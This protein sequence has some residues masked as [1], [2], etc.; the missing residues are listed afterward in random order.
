MTRTL[1]KS[2]TQIDGKGEIYEI[3]FCITRENSGRFRSE[4]AVM[5]KDNGNPKIEHLDSESERMQKVAEALFKSNG[6]HGFVV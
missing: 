6:S 2:F 3:R 1:F 4:V 5:Y